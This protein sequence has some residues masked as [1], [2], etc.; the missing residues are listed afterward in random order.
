M[1][2][3]LLFVLLGLSLTI[4]AA[5]S[6][7]AMTLE[8]FALTG[9][10]SFMDEPPIFEG[11]IFNGTLSPGT[12]WLA[13]DDTNWP[14][15]DPETPTNERWDYIFAHY[16]TYD[17]TEGNEGWDGIFPPAASGEPAS[18]W[19]FFTD[20]GDT[21]GGLATGLSIT[22]RDYDADEIVDEDEYAS[23]TIGGTFVAYINWSGGCFN[24]MCGQGAFHGTVDVINAET[25]EEQL[26]IPSS[27]S[28]T[29]KMFL[30]D[31]GC[32]TDSEISTWG[33]IKSIYK[34]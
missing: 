29:G 16:F 17:D 23:K 2:K 25:W 4:Y 28:A 33:K 26:D 14:V 31:E 6:A 15:D 12:F 34:D 7:S 5:T 22:I 8:T 13:F 32:Q 9:T 1:F 10:G 30:F 3:R 24:S 11:V 18:E 20:A 19:R 27:A 21:L